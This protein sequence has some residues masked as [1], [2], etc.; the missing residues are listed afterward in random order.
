[1]R[2]VS[3]VGNSGSGKS[4]LAARLAAQL[5]VPHVELD[6]L[7]HQPGWTELPGPEFRRHV[8]A[9]TDGEGWVI[10]GNYSA[11][12][13]LVWQRADTVVWLDL[14]RAIVLRRIVGRTLARAI[15]RKTLWN[16]N[17]ERWRNLTTLDPE[18]SVIAWSWTHRATYRERYGGAME[19]P[20]WAHCRFVRLRSARDV[21]AFLAGVG[22]AR[23]T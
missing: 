8:A 22:A 1:V 15:L 20:A 2:R 7:F 14:P 3:V 12:R 17:R 21:E 5:G 13:P 18:Q 23:R 4:T 10:D 16:G 19:D 9:A 6:A 11:V